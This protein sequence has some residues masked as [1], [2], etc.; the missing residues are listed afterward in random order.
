LQYASALSN[1]R[2]IAFIEFHRRP[3]VQEHAVVVRG[4]V[5]ANL[6]ELVGKRDAHGGIGFLRDGEFVES[7]VEELAPRL[8]DG[9]R[10]AKDHRFFGGES[11]CLEPA[12]D[13]GNR[14]SRAR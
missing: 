1:L 12:D 4:G 6:P 11:R 9:V 10:A 5:G 13:G 3:L 2:E 14:V 7:V 8:A